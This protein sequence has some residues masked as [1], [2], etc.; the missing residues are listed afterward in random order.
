[1]SKRD[2]SN[3][4]ILHVESWTISHLCFFIGTNN[5]QDHL[6]NIFHNKNVTVNG[7]TKKTAIQTKQQSK[8]YGKHKP[9][10][11]MWVRHNLF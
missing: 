3:I 2:N 1:M 5:T 7:M 10:K 11:K 9:L 8:K 6:M 4:T